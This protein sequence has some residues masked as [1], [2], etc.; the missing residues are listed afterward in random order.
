[1]YHATK[2]LV[3]QNDALFSYFAELARLSNN[4]RNATLFR[5]RQV[6]TFVE[7]PEAQ[8]T[9]NEREIHDEIT[10]ALPLMGPKFKMPTKGKAFLSYA[11]LEA[12]L[13]V[14]R[15]PNYF[16]EG[17]PRQTCQQLIKEVVFNMK[18]FYAACRA[19]KKNPSAF[20]GRPQLPGY[21]KSGGMRKVIFTN[22]DCVLY[23]CASGG[24]E[25]KF[26]KTKERLYIGDMPITGR[27]K[28]VEVLPSHGIFVVSLIWDDGAGQ[29]EPV[30]EPKRICAIDL[31]VN[32][33]AAITNNLGLPCLLFKGG[34][35]KS[36]NQYYN[37]QVAK[38]VSEQT[39]GSTKKFVPTEAFYAMCRWREN[40]LSD[41]LN[42][43]AVR[44]IQWCQDNRIDTIVIGVNKFW[45]QGSD[46]DKT[47][48]QNFVQLPFDRFK[49]MIKYRAERVGILV[50]EHEE[51]YTSKASF[52][53][54]DEIPVYDPDNVYENGERI[55]YTFSG[56]RLGRGLY[57]SADGSI[58]NA[59]LNGSA[60]IMRKT[61]PEAF[62]IGEGPH[63][64]EVM[65]IHHPEEEMMRENRVRQ[66]QIAK[67]ISRS[68]Q[69]RLNR[70]QH[71][72]ILLG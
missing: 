61:L 66:Q 21:G 50:I 8:W 48:N 43:T 54:K 58:I 67:P 26:P 3:K 31:G 68:K 18:G 25:V 59:D 17:L 5:V 14:T 33:L 51:S 53:D 7:K 42:K 52:L 11:F 12:L 39:K 24:L 19:Y 70:K 36:I 63:F 44:I 30:A 55:R 40:H 45:K 29:P 65:V 6:L 13:Q 15:N 49:K 62:T 9:T 28:Q 20:T 72:V 41:I 46:M 2:T 27:L 37:K 47:N 1:M 56:R 64:D 60:N 10:A 71:N 38:I 35:A 16:A 22:Q 34:V 69:K 32:N 57:K 23:P 4:L